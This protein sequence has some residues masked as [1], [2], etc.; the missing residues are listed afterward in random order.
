MPRPAC[1]D[2]A[3]EPAAALGKQPQ[4]QAAELSEGEQWGKPP[5]V[6]RDMGIAHGRTDAVGL[7]EHRRH[8][9]CKV[10]ETSRRTGN[11][12]VDGGKPR[13]RVV[14]S[15]ASLDMR[16]VYHGRAVGTGFGVWTLHTSRS[17]AKSA[18]GQINHKGR[19]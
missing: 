11:C 4:G 19:M 12:K 13:E 8:P 18:A 3:G 5:R 15:H 9:G 2:A 1:A 6:E 7:R 14:C 17:S 10:R 16:A